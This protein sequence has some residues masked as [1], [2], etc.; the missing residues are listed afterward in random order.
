[1]AKVPA[2][3]AKEGDSRPSSSSSG[4]SLSKGNSSNSGSL[5]EDGSSLR[6]SGRARRKPKRPFDSEPSENEE[7]S[8]A[9]ADGRKNKARAVCTRNGGKRTVRYR[10]DSEDEAK[11]RNSRQAAELK[12]NSSRLAR[13]VNS[14]E[15]DDDDDHENEDPRV[16]KQE[17]G[18]IKRCSR[19]S[20]QEASKRLRTDA[21]SSD[22]DDV[23]SIPTYAV[24][25]RGRL[26]K[27]INH[28]HQ[29]SYSE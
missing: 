12:G 23:P 29:D 8:P 7:K 18:S 14:D 27:I 20:A 1:M 25:S 2:P 5:C 19:Q 10:E 11:K 4:S 24:S 6:R 16:K 15:D 9:L 22:D 28:S 21:T 17:N 3:V 13:K 26:R